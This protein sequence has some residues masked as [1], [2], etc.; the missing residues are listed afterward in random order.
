MIFLKDLD[1]RLATKQ[2]MLKNI[3]D[4]LFEL[5]QSLTYSQK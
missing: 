3:E 4:K 2:L 1:E 5:N